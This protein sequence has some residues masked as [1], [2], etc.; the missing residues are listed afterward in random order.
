M[1]QKPEKHA[2]RVPTVL[3]GIGGIGGQIVRLVDNELKNYDKKFVRMLVL[4]TNTNDLSKLDKTNIPYVQTSENMTVS[5]YLR[6][7]KRF[8][9]WFPYNPLLNGK[10]L[11]EGAG[12]VRSVS[13]LGALASEAAGR[14]EKIKDAITEVSRNVGSTIHKTVRVMIVGSVCGG[15][16]SG[17]GIQLPFLVRDMIDEISNMPNAIVRGLFIMPDIVEEVQDTDQKRR[18][19]YV[20]GFAFL[21]EL[22]AFNKAQ[23]F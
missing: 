16:G 6:R 20:N 2:T 9:D 13:R 18:S 1:A 11:I 5:D 7:N 19:V 10:N 8:E 15:T 17:M 23:T 3:I 12:Q 22:N 21:R 4:D 14:F